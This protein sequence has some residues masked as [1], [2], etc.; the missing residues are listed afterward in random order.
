[1]LN[2]KCDICGKFIKFKTMYSWAI[3]YSFPY[4]GIEKDVF[5]CETDTQKYGPVQSNA[6]PYNNDMSPYQGINKI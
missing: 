4:G 3:I 2:M 6:K 5:R 1:M